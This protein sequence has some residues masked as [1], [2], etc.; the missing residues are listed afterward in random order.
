MA[1]TQ[2]LTKQ[3]LIG[4]WA[5][6]GN[7]STYDTI[8]ALRE[9]AHDEFLNQRGFFTDEGLAFFD[10]IAEELKESAVYS[11]P[12]KLFSKID[13]YLQGSRGE[14]SLSFS[15]EELAVMIAHVGNHSDET[16]T[17]T[18]REM[19]ANCWGAEYHNLT[20]EE[21]TADA[22]LNLASDELVST[23]EDYFRELGYI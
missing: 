9:Y 13:D 3:Q 5:C 6:V 22:H 20:G 19:M 12:Y 1:F 11:M 4:V 14:D 17:S 18:V 21:L 15:D 23:I 7:T 8:D 2:K 10:G 16:F